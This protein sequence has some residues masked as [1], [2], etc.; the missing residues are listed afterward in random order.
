MNNID[1]SI[2][3]G[4]CYYGAGEKSSKNIIPC[5]NA[6]S[7]NYAC[8]QAT[9]YCLEYGACWNYTYDT[10][11]VA[12]CTD[13]DYTDPN[14]PHKD[15]S[16]QQI[17]GLVQCKD[18]ADASG[19]VVWSG[20]PGAT[21]KTALGIPGQCS[22]SGTSSGLI[23]WPSSL[24]GVASLP[25]AIGEKI[26]FAKSTTMSTSTSASPA[27]TAA[28]TSAPTSGSSVSPS[29][30]ASSSS[31]SLSTAEKAG[32]GIGVTSLALIFTG[33]ATIF[34]LWRRRTR[35]DHVASGENHNPGSNGIVSPDPYEMTDSGYDG[36][37]SQNRTPY[38]GQDNSD[39]SWGTAYKPELP[40][41]TAQ[42]LYGTAE[43]AADYVHP[44][45][46]MSPVEAP[47]TPVNLPAIPQGHIIRAVRPVS[48]IS[49]GGCGTSHDPHESGTVTMSDI[50]SQWT[51]SPPSNS[52]NWEHGR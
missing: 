18:S 5:G 26:S 33:V 49:T 23:I 41:N 9:D 34:F 31:D 3:N 21:T 22:C 1:L 42:Y 8:C 30:S 46:N 38:S 50:S 43:L 44:N 17:L 6:A 10:T 51:A 47:M 2:S 12:G 13:A 20:C 25:S 28:T 7:G 40:V 39:C 27:H 16:N 48:S 24:A 11:Y 15:S 14:C 37:R 4:T 29:T 45:A 35:R 32:I 36:P 19:S 52:G